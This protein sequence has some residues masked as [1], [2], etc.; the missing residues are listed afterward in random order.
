MRSKSTI[1]D[2][3]AD[4]ASEPKEPGSSFV[5]DDKYGGALVK[6]LL[7][8]EDKEVGTSAG[9]SD[10]LPAGSSHRAEAFLRRLRACVRLAKDDED[11]LLNVIKDIRHLSAGT[12]LIRK[13]DRA[14]DVHLLLEGWAA[15]YDIVPD[16][17][18]SITAFLLPGDVLDQHVTVLGEMDHSIVTLTD[19]TVAFLPNGRLE[20]VAVRRP[21]IASA[22]W[23]STLVDAA[24]LRAW[25]VNIGRR[26]A[27]EA[28][29]HLLCELHARL[30][31]V[32]FSTN[33]DFELPLTQEEVADALG[34]TPTHV[35]RMLKRLREEGYITLRQNK[36]VI[37]DVGKLQAATGFES[38]YLHCTP[39]DLLQLMA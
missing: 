26:G 11:E 30:A 8:V 7:E 37:L 16:G 32:G 5:S 10:P 4:S 36:L 28:I 33:T 2:K 35:N 29:G 27:F 39:V 23:W 15:R 24:V 3:R 22:L 14:H 18:R 31:R 34:L 38:S 20:S 9:T 25:L 1:L 17:G 6:F 13:G 19:A 12:H 21:L